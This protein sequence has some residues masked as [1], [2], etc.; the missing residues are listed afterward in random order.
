MASLTKDDIYQHDIRTI[1]KRDEFEH[2]LRENGM[3][4]KVENIRGS[5]R[6]YYA[7]SVRRRGKPEADSLIEQAF[8]NVKN[9]N[10][11]TEP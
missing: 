4:Y 7:V 9:K 1:E 11:G 8:D 2:P 5:G 3:R 10:S 6:K